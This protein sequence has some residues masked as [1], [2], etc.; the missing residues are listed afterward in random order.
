M[1]RFNS[2]N[3]VSLISFTAD[4]DCYI[5]AH[6]I[7]LVC[8]VLHLLQ[9]SACGLYKLEFHS[10]GSVLCVCV[11]VGRSSCFGGERGSSGDHSPMSDQ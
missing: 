1:L 7:Q 3:E 8:A 10:V 6:C 2:N 11:C 9:V 5:E 4:F